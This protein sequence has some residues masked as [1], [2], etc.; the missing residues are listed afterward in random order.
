MDTRWLWYARGAGVV[1]VDERGV[2]HVR[3]WEESMCVVWVVCVV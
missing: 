3:R 2:P 1:L